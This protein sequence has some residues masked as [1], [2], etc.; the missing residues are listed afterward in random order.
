MVYRISCSPSQVGTLAL[1]NFAQEPP[2]PYEAGP[3]LDFVVSK[4][5]TKGPNQDSGTDKE[6][7]M[8]RPRRSRAG[9][10]TFSASKFHVWCLATIWLRLI[11]WFILGPDTRHFSK[12]GSIFDQFS[13]LSSASGFFEKLNMDR[14]T[15]SNRDTDNSTKSY[16]VKPSVVKLIK[17]LKRHKSCTVSIKRILTLIQRRML[18]IDP[19]G[20]AS[21]QEVMEILQEIDRESE[22]LQKT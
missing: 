10:P 21:T 15:R 12:P 11:T 18:V 17:Q 8:K 5:S 1:G 13:G 4:K 22:E 14:P 2:Q 9:A 3:E 7:H 16:W 6:F 19:A 20:R